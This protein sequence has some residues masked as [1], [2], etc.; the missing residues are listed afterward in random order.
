GTPRNDS[1]SRFAVTQ[2]RME[3][4]IAVAGATGSLDPHT[5][6]KKVIVD[7]GAFD[8][9][10][11]KANEWEVPDSP[12]DCQSIVRFTIAVLNMINIPGP[13]VHKNI[14][15]IE[16]APTIGIEVDP[17]G[18]LGNPKRFHPNGIWDLTL[19][20]GNGGCNNFEAT[21]KFTDSGITKYYAGGTSLVF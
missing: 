15:A 16:T 7:Q 2:K 17:P 18:G 10:G 19:I 9:N 4:A 3:R 11:P 8:L 14:Y 12:S 6:V 20:D 5:I 1:D 21:A 13:A